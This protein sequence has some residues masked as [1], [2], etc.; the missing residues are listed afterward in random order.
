M[1]DVSGKRDMQQKTVYV[2]ASKTDKTEW[3]F[4]S[5]KFHQTPKSK[6]ESS[7]QFPP[8]KAISAI[9]PKLCTTK[10]AT[11]FSINVSASASQP[12]LLVERPKSST[13]VLKKNKQTRRGYKRHKTADRTTI[14]LL[15]TNADGL[16]TKKESFFNLLD[17]EKPSIFTIQETKL[18]REKQIE[19]PGYKIFEKIREN[20]SGG[21]IMIGIETGLSRKEPVIIFNGDKEV[22]MMLI[23]ISL[24]SMNL[25]IM[26]A[27][28]PQE[29][30][31]PDT[32]NN[33]YQKLEEEIMKCEEDDCGLIIEMDANA[34]L[35]SELIEGDPN[36]MSGNGKILWGI[37]QRRNCVVVNGTPRCSGV[38]TRSRTR[39]GRKEE[40]V[41]DYI[42]VN[43]KAEPFLQEMKIDEKKEKVLTR[44][45]KKKIVTSDHNILSCSLNIPHRRPPKQRIERFSLRNAED[46]VKFKEETTHTSRFTE[47][48]RNEGSVREQGKRW[49]KVL[50]NTIHKT[51]RKIR[52][53]DNTAKRSKIQL[54]MDERKTIRKKLENAGCVAEKHALEDKLEVVERNIG[55]ECSAKHMDLI[56]QHVQLKRPM[57]KEI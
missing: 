30:A 26:T 13:M 57:G 6:L 43:Q 38:L 56:N 49:L 21:G 23:E 52:V 18:K 4:S 10:N 22:E 33:F 25:R 46:L 17:D 37:V 20:K 1:Q 27:Y 42:I 40:S 36:P 9:P 45:L 53:T 50:M 16:T 3:K 5:G 55:E 48:F 7:L 41:L 51:F 35:G 14:K 39:E 12:T 47:C 19:K 31:L 29:D 28:G 15:G 34:K 11:T 44:Y 8:E 2:F 54:M 32:I 24:D